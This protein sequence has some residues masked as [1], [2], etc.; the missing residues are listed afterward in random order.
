MR[1][2]RL[3]VTEKAVAEDAA[4]AL[5]CSN[6][7]SRARFRDGPGSAEADAGSAGGGMSDIVERRG[8]GK[9]LFQPT[10]KTLGE[11]VTKVM[12]TYLKRGCGNITSKSNL[13]Y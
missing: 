9:L 2:R 10:A 3:V 13:I 4:E 7:S 12:T 1:R 5:P 6:S 8:D 11:V